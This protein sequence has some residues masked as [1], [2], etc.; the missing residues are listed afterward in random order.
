MHPQAILERTQKW[1]DTHTQALI[2]TAGRLVFAAV[3]APYFWASALTKLGPGVAGLWTPSLGA[4]AQIFPRAMEAASYDPG[5]LGWWHTFVVLLG[6][7]GEMALPLLIV[8]GLWTRWAALGMVVFIVVQSAT[9]VVGHGV[10]TATVGAWFDADPGSAILDQRTLW[11]FLL[12]TIARMGA[13]PL[14]L[15]RLWAHKHRLAAARLA[16]AKKGNR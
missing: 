9:D 16:V 2:P 12:L 4:Y 5:Q 15:D 10:D 11:V 14:S 1:L 3:L 6:T 8:I 7:W 13:G